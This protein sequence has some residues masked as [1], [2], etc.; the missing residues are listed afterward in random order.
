MG[1]FAKLILQIEPIIIT[2]L[3]ANGEAKPNTF[4]S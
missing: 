3:S 4:R 1:V 2:D